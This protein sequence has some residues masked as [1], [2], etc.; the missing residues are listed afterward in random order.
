MMRTMAGIQQHAPD[1]PHS[2]IFIGRFQPFHNGHEQVIRNLVERYG[3]LTV[4]I[5]S[6]NES[7]LL[8][9]PFTLEERKEMLAIALGDLGEK[10]R[11]VRIDD[12]HHDRLWAEHVISLGEFSRFVSDNDWV[13]RCLKGAL[14]EIPYPGLIDRDVLEGKHIRHAMA[15]GGEWK[16]RVSPK[17]AHYLERMNAEGL[18]RK[19]LKTHR[20]QSK[21]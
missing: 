19:L 13:R 14:E 21:N 6:A 17:I 18:M 8:R 12:K 5:G 15:T 1:K 2:V 7:G 11:I 20:E 4:G 3:T 9:N 10:V 16:G